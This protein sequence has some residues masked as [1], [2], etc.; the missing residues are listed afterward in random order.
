MIRRRWFVASVLAVIIGVFVSIILNAIAEQGYID[1]LVLPLSLRSI[2]EE[3]FSGDTSLQQVLLPEGIQRI[4]S[5][6]FYGAS[7]KV[8]NLPDTI[9]YIA[10]DAFTGTAM[11]YIIV[12]EGTY[13][14]EWAKSHGLLNRTSSYLKDYVIE[15]GIIT[16]YIGQGGNVIVPEYDADGEK[17]IGIGSRAFSSCNTVTNITLPSTIVSLGEGAFYDCENLIRIVIPDTITLIPDNCFYYCKSLSEIDSLGSICEIGDN[18]FCYCES[19]GRIVLP[20]NVMRVGVGNLSSCSDGVSIF[21][22]NRNSQTA[23]TISS[24][25]SWYSGSN[26]S[27]YDIVDESFEYR[28]EGNAL[29]LVKYHG[30]DPELVLPSWVEGL[31]SYALSGIDALKSV[32]ITNGINTIPLRC[33]SDSYNLTSVIL[34]ASITTIDDDAFYHCNSLETVN[35]PKGVKNIP[36]QCFFECTQLHRVKLPSSIESIGEFAFYNCSSLNNINIPYSVTS[37]GLC[38]FYHCYELQEL[39]LPDNIVFIGQSG[40]GEYSC[41]PYSSIMVKCHRNSITAKTVSNTADYNT[42]FNFSFTSP[43]EEDYLY[44]WRDD[45]LYLT[46]YQ[47]KSL[48]VVIPEWV[49][50]LRERLFLDSKTQRVQSIKLNDKIDSI[51][52]DCFCNCGIQEIIIPNNVKSIGEIAF[53]D[54]DLL[55]QIVLQS[56]ITSIH[57]EAFNNCDRIHAIVESGSYAEDYCISHDISYEILFPLSA[58]AC[59]TGEI[60]RPFYS[61]GA[62]A[63]VEGGL[64]PYNYQFQFYRNGAEIYTT[65]WVSKSTYTFMPTEEVDY[66]FAVTV[67]DALGNTVSASS[68]PMHPHE[69]TEEEIEERERKAFYRAMK[70]VF[71][72]AKWPDQSEGY[73]Y[74]KSMP[75]EWAWYQQWIS[76]LSGEI[77]D[78]D[79]YVA[80]REWLFYNAMKMAATGKSVK[81]TGSLS[82]PSEVGTIDKT[83]KLTE[84]EILDSLCGWVGVDD[85]STEYADKLKGIFQEFNAGSINSYQAENKLR[86]LGV[87]PGAVPEYLEKMQLMSVI[88][89]I[90]QVV[91][92]INTSNMVYSNTKDILNQFVVLNSLDMNQLYVIAESYMNRGSAAQQDVGRLL[93][94]FAVAS[95]EEQVSMIICGKGASICL[96]VL[97]DRALDAVESQ[98]SAS[99]PIAAYKLTVAAIDV[100]TGIKS[101]PVKFHELNYAT[102]NTQH[103][104][105]EF[106]VKQAC[107]LCNPCEEEFSETYHAF[108]NYYEA[109]ALSEE[110]FVALVEASEDAWL[111]DLYMGEPLRIASAR[112]KEN[113]ET[114]HGICNGMREIYALW[115]SEDYIGAK[116][117][118]EQLLMDYRGYM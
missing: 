107:Y 69:P 64:K 15:N 48:D 94:G 75:D 117:E 20:D 38:A 104:W 9:E 56:S 40:I 66:S 95:K 108:I 100:L 111:S 109:V 78:S 88:D 54:C 72:N 31:C 17:V 91:R 27:F 68:D 102:E 29:Y 13:A 10:D 24:S 49:D 90:P 53:D 8:I 60:N 98:L 19:L 63:I 16:S 57:D 82:L 115:K 28:W 81:L 99:T 71:E 77:S 103:C 101:M 1:Q 74:Y 35:L 22:C 70:S 79:T 12:N 83:I 23:S 73:A 52:Y 5:K 86:E 11:T 2:E 43:G 62:K 92:T 45:K 67:R 44:Q 26:Y 85:L 4:E 114:L 76:L 33:F 58:T 14:Y 39:S 113:A 87:V 112:A 51:P 32:V 96:D 25:P 30:T 116:D 93:M 55:S 106:R 80:E 50:A 36:S 7:L 41:D 21:V 46:A 42:H 34:P 89:L 65:D 110:A 37:I 84:S 61:I 18:A 97:A 59:W 118:L 47:G 105:N 3:T 6:A